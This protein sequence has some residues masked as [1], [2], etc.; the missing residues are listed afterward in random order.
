MMLAKDF[1]LPRLPVLG[2]NAKIEFQV[3]AYNLFNNLNF[4]PSNM[5]TSITASNFGTETG[6]LA[7]RVV[8]LGA[9]FSF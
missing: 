9:R 2:E 6:A 4:N 5:V 7:A 8:T 3:D 1:G